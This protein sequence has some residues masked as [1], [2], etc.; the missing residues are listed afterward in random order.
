M[1][2]KIIF[3]IIAVLANS[4]AAQNIPVT[5]K[6][7]YLLIQG[8]FEKVIDTCK[9]MLASDS[10]NPEIYYKMGIAFQNIME[11]DSS[12]SNFYHAF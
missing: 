12:V 6:I 1:K 3:P 5:S 8:D 10:L 7:D 9:T 4:L 2:L 11:A